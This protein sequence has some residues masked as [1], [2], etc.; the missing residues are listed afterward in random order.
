[1]ALEVQPIPLSEDVGLYVYQNAAYVWLAID[2]PE[3]SYGTVDMEL[4]TESLPSPLNLH[5]S[6]QLG[7]WTVGD[8]LAQP[9]KATSDK[10]WNISGWY[11]NPLWA[12]GID[13]TGAEPRFKLKNGEIREIQLS[14]KRFGRGTWQFKLK[15][16]AI[17]RAAGG[18]YSLTFPEKKRYYELVVK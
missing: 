14:K 1:A 3:G 18:F 4:L 8:T 5:V 6:A 7:E 15:V 12:N 9:T 2:Y 16:N 13:T 11:A 10:W 17:R